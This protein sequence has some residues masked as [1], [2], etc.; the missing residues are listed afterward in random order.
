MRVHDTAVTVHAHH[1]QRDHRGVDGRVLHT[2]RRDEVKVGNVVDF[3]VD[4][5]KIYWKTLKATIF[6]K[7]KNLS[8]YSCP[9]NLYTSSNKINKNFHL[10]SKTSKDGFISKLSK[11]N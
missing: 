9:M 11:N 5:E 10:F 3:I 7:K 8:I 1:H 6:H 4:R 2:H